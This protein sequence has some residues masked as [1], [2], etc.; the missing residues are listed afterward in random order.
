MQ[1]L[2]D[3]NLSAQLSGVD[4]VAK[5][6]KYHS[7]CCIKYQTEAERKHNQEKRMVGE[8]SIP[9][10]SARIWQ[11]NREV[12]KKAFEALCNFYKKLLLKTKAY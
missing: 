1:W 12:H 8:G 9:E 5:E 10:T 4:F 6:V 2:A 7:H 3:A 11:L